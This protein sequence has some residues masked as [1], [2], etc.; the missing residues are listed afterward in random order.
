MLV[1]D[2]DDPVSSDLVLEEELDL[3]EP[4]RHCMNIDDG[5]VPSPSVTVQSQ[6]LL[7]FLPS[8]SHS[9]EENGGILK[10]LFSHTWESLPKPLHL[11]LSVDASPGCGGIAW[12]AGQIL[13][14]YL[15]HRGPAYLRNKNILELGSGTGLVGLVAG[16]LQGD[17]RVWITD[18]SPLLP[19]MKRNVALNEVE[20]NVTVAELD[21]GT[22]IPSGIPKPDVILAADCVYFEPA[23]PLLVETLDRLAGK[24][25]EILFCYK[26]RRKADK[27]FFSLLKKKFTW[28]DVEDD[29]NRASYNREAI[30]LTRLFKIIR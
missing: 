4:L 20:N 29:P 27:R 18:Q 2:L 5:I 30:T 10:L 13:A 11:S 21:W 8:Q 24:D 23:F 28:K 12:P 7:G 17:C 26:K 25:T 19:I 16:M 15:I 9:L 6:Q 1:L 22:S 3:K 14:T